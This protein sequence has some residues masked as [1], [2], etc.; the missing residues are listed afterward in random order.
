MVQK[1]LSEE[2][3]FEQNPKVREQVMYISEG[4][5]FRQSTKARARPES[6]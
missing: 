5:Y 3:A 6:M 2:V 4:E 1:D